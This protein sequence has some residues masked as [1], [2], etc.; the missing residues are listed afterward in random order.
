MDLYRINDKTISKQKITDTID[1]ILSYRAQ[2]L[3]QTEVSDKLNLDRIFISRLEK[4]GEIRKGKNIAI[5]GFPI[6]NIQQVQNISEKFGVNFTLLLSEQQRWH[7][8]E[9]KEGVDL[10]NQ[11]L[12][13]VNDLKSF[14]VVIVIASDKRIRQISN[15]LDQKI[16]PYPIGKS[17]IKEDVVVNTDEIEKL[18]ATLC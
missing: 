6:E 8:V 14:D 4:M 16:V 3:S 2:G 17:P 12:K 5:I 13:L 10:F 7:F 1:K 9:S 18:L 15:L 11:I